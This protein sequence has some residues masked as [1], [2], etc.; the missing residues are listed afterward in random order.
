MKN[1]F[2]LIKIIQK[3]SFKRGHF[4]LSAGGTS[5]YYI[6]LRATICHP[7]GCNLIAKLVYHKIQDLCRMN[8]TRDI[9]AIGCIEV[10]G[11]PIASGVQSLAYD[12]YSREYRVFIVR[13]KVKEHG[14]KK[15]VEGLIKEGD[16]V[17]IVED[18][19]TSGNS[20]LQVVEAIKEYNCHITAIITIVDRG[21]GAREK[22]N[23]MGIPYYPL[24][25]IDEIK[26]VIS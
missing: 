25:G 16:H 14:R 6:D 20:I 21:E 12:R 11:I 5:D 1:K 24:F 17:V 13:K 7:V 9:D 3:Y 10:A 19:A 4:K 8:K 23:E 22:F 2:D 26:E 15:R 18:V